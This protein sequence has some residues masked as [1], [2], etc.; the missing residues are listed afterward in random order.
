LILTID[1]ACA[2]LWK[3]LNYDKRQAF[4]RN[5]LCPRKRMRSTRK[6]SHNREVLGVNAG[7]VNNKN[8]GGLEPIL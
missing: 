5:E 6:L 3:E 7:H 2:R 1:L 8:E 4:F